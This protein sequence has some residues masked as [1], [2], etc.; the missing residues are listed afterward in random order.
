MRLFLRISG[1]LLLFWVSPF[2]NIFV[3]I[4]VSN[5]PQQINPLKFFDSSYTALQTIALLV[6]RVTVFT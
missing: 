1:S 2:F 6:R 3:I 4:K 5:L